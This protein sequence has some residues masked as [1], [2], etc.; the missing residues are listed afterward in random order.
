MVGP[1]FLLRSRPLAVRGGLAPRD[2]RSTASI[3]KTRL[4]NLR[5]S[6]RKFRSQRW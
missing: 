6:Y 2:G 3:A 5:K 1:L 4:I